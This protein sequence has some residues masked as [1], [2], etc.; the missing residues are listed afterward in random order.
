MNTNPVTTT[1]P[2]GGHMLGNELHGL[3]GTWLG[4]SG[5]VW[6]GIAVA[7]VMLFIA[8]TWRNA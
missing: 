1:S 4:L 8:I 2:Q 7:V 6:I 5:Y 3:A